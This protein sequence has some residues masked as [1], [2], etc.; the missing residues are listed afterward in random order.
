[1]ADADQV[2]ALVK[3][4]PKD[5]LGDLLDESFKAFTVLDTRWDH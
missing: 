2:S 5:E 1:L 4:I 3:S